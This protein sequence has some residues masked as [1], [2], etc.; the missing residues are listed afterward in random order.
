MHVVVVGAGAIGTVIASAIEDVTVVA[1]GA[2]LAAIRMNGLVLETP[3]GTLQRDVTVTDEVPDAADVVVLATKTQDAEA[4][5]RQLALR[6]PRE[7]PIAC[8]TNGLVAEA[9][10]ARWFAH[11]LGVV[12]MCPA[13]HVSDD[14]IQAWGAPVPGLFDIGPWFGDDTTVAAALVAALRGLDGRVRADIRRWKRTKLL[15]NL[16]NAV[17]ALVGPQTDGPLVDAIRAEARA[18]FAAAGWDYASD[19]E[20]AARRAGW[21]SGPIAGRTRGGGSTWQSLKRGA[22]I[23]AEYFNGE[24]CALGRE[25]GIATPANAFVLRELARAAAAGLAPGTISLDELTNRSS[26]TL[27]RRTL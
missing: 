4:A 17:N 12:V 19:E 13:T 15:L 3:R 11:V 9:L 26:L 16:A 1:R 7:T 27:A 18:C 8:A 22:P 6:L 25:H 5:L 23:E 21:S 20:D 2:R 14:A 24:I 10:A